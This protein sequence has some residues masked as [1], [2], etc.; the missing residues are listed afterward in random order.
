MFQ[1]FSS[2]PDHF[3]AVCASLSARGLRLALQTCRTARPVSLPAKLLPSLQTDLCSEVRASR[4]ALPSNVRVK[5]KCLAP[6]ID[7]PLS[8]SRG[9]LNG[10]PG[11][12]LPV[13][14]SR[15]QRPI[16]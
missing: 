9:A 11:H 14:V 1:P 13:A 2:K 8:E 15:T 6:A 12:P 16:I 4:D 10:A 5:W 7:D 3:W